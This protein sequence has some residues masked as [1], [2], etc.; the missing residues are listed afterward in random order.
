MNKIAE[1]SDDNV[2]ADEIFSE[3]ID[4]MNDLGRYK[5]HSPYEMML[6]RTPEP[7]VG[8]VFGQDH[9]L[10]ILS[11]TYEA[12]DDEYVKNQKVRLEARKAFLDYFQTTSCATG[13]AEVERENLVGQLCYWWSEKAK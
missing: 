13:V 11:K 4:A 9:K 8:D 3:A 7:L 10:P 5:G 1:E 2:T 12:D 6:G